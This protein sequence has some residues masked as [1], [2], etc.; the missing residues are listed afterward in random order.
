MRYPRKTIHMLLLLAVLALSQEAALARSGMSAAYAAEVAKR[1]TIAGYR[2]LADLYRDEGV[3]DKASD[4]YE[5]ASLG[6]GRLGDPNA[7]QALHDQS[8]RYRTEIHLFIDKPVSAA[9]ADLARLEPFAGCYLGVNIEHEEGAGSPE[10]F[11]SKVGKPHA[12]F[13]TY[14]KYGVDFPASLARRLAALHAGLQIAWEPG[15]L[16][17][18]RDDTYLARFCEAIGKSGIPVFL[19]FASEMNG[20][21][22]PYHADPAFYR[23]AF[24]LV[25]QRVHQSVPNAAMV[26]CPN[27]V[28]ESN[29]DSY[30]PG[31]DAV[32]WVG[33]NFYSVLFND[34]DRSR[35]AAWH[36]PSDFL[37]YVYGRYSAH[38]PMMV[39]EWAATHR[40]VVDGI[41]RPQF[42]IDKIRQF[43][44]ALPREYPRVKAVHWLSMNTQ[45]YASGERRL[46]DFSLL[47][48]ADVASAY[49]EAVSPDYFLSAFG[50]DPPSAT[51]K[52]L[53]FGETVSGVIRLSAAIHTYDDD[54]DVSYTAGGR[55]FDLSRKIGPYELALDTRAFPNGTLTAEVTVTDSFNR[56]S[57]QLAWKLIVKN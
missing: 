17:E 24:R 52:P 29:I 26:W 2:R 10:E 28:P 46:N 50:G 31:D 56:V 57:G 53:G 42:A 47:A 41:D 18:V 44:A 51:P 21:W 36:N 23:E 7:A 48:D 14:R 45:K 1:P 19:R 49:S 6:Y 55:T 25:A 38:H 27:V 40:S 54:P 8:L 34:G 3:F 32:D 30:F 37:R 20:D 13:F 33:V 5:K 35:D 4:A 12:I 11:D 22:T 16:A 43:Y 15:S 9:K 39:G